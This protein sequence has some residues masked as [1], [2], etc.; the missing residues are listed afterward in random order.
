MTGAEPILLWMDSLKPTM[1]SSNSVLL[2]G[3]ARFVV[4]D[5]G[6]AP[7]LLRRH[8]ER[9]RAVQPTLPLCIV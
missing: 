3:P 8:L 9:I 2:Q 1:L 5:A 4:L 6:G 7:A